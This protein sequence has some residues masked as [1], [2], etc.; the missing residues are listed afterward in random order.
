MI[1][2]LIV[3]SVPSMLSAFLLPFASHFRNQGWQV[4]AMAY[5][6][7]DST[8]CQKGF[9]HIWDVE[10]SRNPLVLKNFMN[11]PSRVKQVVEQ[12]KYDIVHVHTPVA[13]FVSRYALNSL[14]KQGK[15]KL[16]YTA[17]GFHFHPNGNPLKNTIFLILEKLA[18][19]WTDYLV[20][21]NRE[22]E[23]A[24]IR[25][26]L[27]PKERIRYMPGIG[28]DLNYYN[29]Y[30]VSE[31]ALA[32]L[33]Q[34]LGI[35]RENPMFLSVAEF[36]PR[37]HHR[38]ILKAFAKLS[39]PN[40]HLAF[41][42]C[43]PLLEE[44]QQLASDL[45]IQSQ[46]HFLGS[47]DDIPT[48]I[49]ASVATILASEQEGLPRCVMESLSL[50]VPVIGTNIRGTQEL[51]KYGSGLLVEVGDVDGLASAM[52]WILK[53]PQDAQSMGKH[54]RKMIEDFYALS[55][56]IKLHEALYSEAISK[57]N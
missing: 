21:I 48:L 3:T 24:A 46:V 6:I 26:H 51:L 49:R 25:H 47:R 9:N 38:D 29:P 52:D 19:A 42:G 57:D 13:S 53:N 33:H 37:K 45:H 27:L 8:K 4:D 31:S 50:E 14:R 30:T 16:I 11:A 5:K 7:S 41:A 23:E 28:V 54:G 55:H 18:G 2:L 20:V 40:V 15:C 36:S 1:K 32:R 35:A 39:R 43:G 10:W 34:E 22:D 17:H 56:I 12:G 44:M